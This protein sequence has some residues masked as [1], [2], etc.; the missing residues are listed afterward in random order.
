MSWTWSSTWIRWGVLH[1]RALALAAWRWAVC[2]SAGAQH[3][4]GDGDGRHGAG[5]QHER[6][7]HAG[8]G[9]G[10]DGEVWGESG[11]ARCMRM[12]QNALLWCL[13]SERLLLWRSD[14]VGFLVWSSPSAHR[15]A[16]QRHNQWCNLHQTWDYR[17]II[18]IN[19]RASVDKPVKHKHIQFRYKAEDNTL[20]NMILLLSVFVLFS[21]INI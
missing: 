7:H 15:A 10:Q 21:S 1:E 9:A 11:S 19:N 14:R 3:P 6:D 17:V 13:G 8:G 4:S 5:D 20:Q 16:S 2:V 12:S 18:Q